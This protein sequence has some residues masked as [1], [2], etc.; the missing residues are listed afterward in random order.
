[1]SK[2]KSKQ[3]PINTTTNTYQTHSQ[4]PH[5]PN[6][7]PLLFH[8]H[9]PRIKQTPDLKHHRFILAYPPQT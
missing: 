8:H 4:K 2:T 6:F 3:H 9:N 1:S 5:N 7:A